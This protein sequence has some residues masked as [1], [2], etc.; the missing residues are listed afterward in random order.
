MDGERM[1]DV[2]P[3]RPTALMPMKNL[4]LRPCKKDGATLS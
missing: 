3:V 4:V 2:T 1:S